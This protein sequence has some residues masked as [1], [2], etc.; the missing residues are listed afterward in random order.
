MFQHVVLPDD[1]HGEVLIERLAFY[2][3][4]FAEISSSNNTDHLKVF[5]KHITVVLLTT[6]DALNWFVCRILNLFCSQ[7]RIQTFLESWSKLF[8][9]AYFLLDLAGFPICLFEG[10]PCEKGI[11]DWARDGESVFTCSELFLDQTR[12]GRHL[13]LNGLFGQELLCSVVYSRQ[14]ERCAR[15]SPT[16]ILFRRSVVSQRIGLCNS[17]NCQR[18]LAFL[19]E[20]R[21]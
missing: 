6:E 19:A 13:A 16:Q 1:L 8:S 21:L 9:L 15:Y 11:L 5:P 10:V 14:N 17:E 18:L 4:N 2:Q 7:V 3:I 20:S 12:T